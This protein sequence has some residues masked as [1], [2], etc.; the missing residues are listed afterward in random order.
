MADFSIW[1]NSGDTALIEH[2]LA[3]YHQ[4]HRNQ[5]LEI[6]PLAEKVASVHAGEF[7]AEIL[8]LLQAM[9]ADLLSHMQK[10]EQVLFPML[11]NGMGRGAAMPIRVMMHEHEEH[12]QTIARLLALTDHFTPPA[13]ACPSWQRLYAALQTLISDLQDHI[14]LENTVLFARALAAG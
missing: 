6:L 4:T 13:Q 14:E 5:F 9:Q 12:E 11:A 7:P 2:I 10:E 3:R 1:Q 8:P